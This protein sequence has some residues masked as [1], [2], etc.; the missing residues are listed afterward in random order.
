MDIPVYL[1]VGFLESGKT[2]FVQS[3]LEDKRFNSG[4]KTLLLVCEEGMEEYAPDEFS[5]GNV[6]MQNIENEEDLSED[7]FK[8]LHKKF[9]F[10]RVVIEYNG[11][12]QLN[13]LYQALP[14]NYPIYQCMMFADANTIL[15]YNANMRNIVVDKINACEVVVFNRCKRDFD[16]MALHKLVRNVSRRPDIAY[17]FDDGDVE[18]DDIEDPLPFDI[19]APVIEIKDVDYALFYRDIIEDM[20]KYDGKAVK[21][22]G[23][24]AKDKKMPKNSFAIGRHVMTC[25]VEDITYAGLVAVLPDNDNTE[26]KNRDWFVITADIKVEKNRL[27]RSKGPVMYVK[28]IVRSNKPTE[29]VATFY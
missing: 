4:E 13:T 21:F 2:K 1:F 24:A 12:W 10:E 7:F 20:N 29:E 16:K 14:E 15:Q 5:G 8:N 11:M 18:Y 9:N 6:Y 3:T 25:C 28:E 17:E 19:N 27:Y 26:V 23:I 22:K